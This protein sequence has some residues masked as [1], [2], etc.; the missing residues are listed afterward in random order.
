MLKTRFPFSKPS[1]QQSSMGNQ[2]DA[3]YNKNNNAWGGN[4]GNQP[5]QGNQ[6]GW[7]GNS[8]WGGQNNNNNAGGW[9]GNQGGN[10]GGQGGWGGNSAWVG[11]NNNNA[12][13]WGGNQG[14][15]GGAWDNLPKGG[16]GGI[17]AGGVMGGMGGGM[18]GGIGGVNGS[19]NVNG[20]IV[21][22]Q[23]LVGTEKK[24]LDT[25]NHQY[26]QLLEKNQGLDVL[27]RSLE[28]ESNHLRKENYQMSTFLKENENQQT[29]D[30]T[31]IVQP[32]D[33]LSDQILDLSSSIKAREDCL[34][35][36]EGKFND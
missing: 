2:W 36:L 5:N 10:Q 23:K 29:L 1:M 18:G 4:K 7:G 32:A 16:M 8:A 30:L 26:T 21:S 34:M 24:H 14:G 27:K 33:V 20:T 3:M 13:G 15:N 31:R 11:Q 19:P 12:G 22:A 28:S 17:I 9:G 6:G 25:M 35:Y